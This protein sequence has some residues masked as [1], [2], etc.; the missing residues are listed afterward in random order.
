MNQLLHGGLRWASNFATG[1]KITVIFL[2]S[3]ERKSHTLGVSRHVSEK[4]QIVNIL[5][6]VGHKNSAAT[7]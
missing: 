6:F 5:G 7:I 3:K 1:A 2:S 4:A